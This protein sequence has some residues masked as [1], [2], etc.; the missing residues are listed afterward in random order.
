MVPGCFRDHPITK[1]FIVLLSAASGARLLTSGRALAPRLSDQGSLLFFLRESRLIQSFNVDSA[2]LPPDVWQ[3]RLGLK[4]AA[5]RWQSSKGHR[6]WMVWLQD[7][8]PLLVL[9]RTKASEPSRVSSTFP[10]VELL[11]ADELHRKSFFSKSP[12]RI[13][14]RSILEEDCI[15]RLTRSPAVAWN[16]SG[17]SAIAG[18]LAF[19]LNSGSHGCL[20]LTLDG[21]QRLRLDGS[22]SSRPLSSAPRSLRR[23]PGIESGFQAFVD[24]TPMNNRLALHWQGASTKPLFSSLLQRRLI[25]DAIE[26]TYGLTPKFQAE[27]LKAPMDLQAK[28]S[29]DGPFKASLQLSLAFDPR[30][31][32]I[33]NKGLASLASNLEQRGLRPEVN[34][35]TVGTNKAQSAAIIWKGSDQNVLGHWSVQ[36]TTPYQ[37]SLQL[38]LGGPLEAVLPSLTLKPKSGLSVRFDAKQLRRLG[39]LK[40]TW[41]ALVQQAGQ[42]ELL[43]KPMLGHRSGQAETWYWLKGQLSLR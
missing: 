5:Q 42:G 26:K 23:P 35:S 37:M 33:V 29:N 24:A 36:S 40:A 27:W 15:D 4:A 31:D 12:S 6:W 21:R 34:Q 11:F 30:H 3:R 2:E 41:P 9:H 38:S 19:A 14:T 28:L 8:S 22:V 20:S 25:S 13:S 32:E 17:L 43:L 39:W 16:P 18:P 7:G 10:D 1:A